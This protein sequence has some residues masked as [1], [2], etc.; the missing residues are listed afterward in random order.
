[1]FGT[2]LD[3][4]MEP[5][6]APNGEAGS[7]TVVVSDITDRVSAARSE[8]AVV[9]LREEKDRASK[10][11]VSLSHEMKSPLT[12]VVALA[13]LLGMND[14]GNLHPDQI[15]RIQVVQQNADRLTLLVNDFL[16][17][18]KMEAGTFE[19]KPTKFQI[20]ELANDLETS[21]EPIATGQDHKIAV[22]APDEHQFAVAD[23]EL[24]RQAIMNL[25]TNASKYSPS[26]TNVSLDIWVDE[27]DLRVTVTDEGP[28]IPHDERDRVF[29]PYSQLDNPDVPG[30]GMGLTIVRQ[31]VELHRGKVWVEDG[32]SGGTPF[33]IWL[34]EA[35]SNG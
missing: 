24:L 4:W 15:E 2:I 30:T 27:N 20:S 5:N 1:V 12:T 29:E 26:N 7:A 18:S 21:F 19:S 6:L 17:I 3:A 31:I 35:V 32:V 11:I 23:R 14:R 9:E 10:F 28:G 22:T 33:A 34:P 13:D 25:L 8:A 16:N